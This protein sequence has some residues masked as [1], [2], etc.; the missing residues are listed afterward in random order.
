[1]LTSFVEGEIAR[2]VRK[3]AWN[4]TFPY[5][6]DSVYVYPNIYAFIIYRFSKEVFANIK[7]YIYFKYTINV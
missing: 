7:I 1:M 6:L 2:C 3:N 5:V 4:P